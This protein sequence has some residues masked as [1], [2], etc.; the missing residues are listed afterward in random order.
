MPPWKFWPTKV[1]ETQMWPVTQKSW[2][3]PL[4]TL[5]IKIQSIKNWYSLFYMLKKIL[6]RL[7]DCK[8]GRLLATFVYL[9]F[10]ILILPGNQRF[11]EV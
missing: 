4:E 11:N 9:L 10:L 1:F 6:C 8:A 7:N 5:K 3:P 2:T